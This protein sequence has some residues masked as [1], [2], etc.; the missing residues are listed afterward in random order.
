MSGSKPSGSGE[1]V[2][3]ASAAADSAA[4]DRG[5]EDSAAGDSAA[6]NSGAELGSVRNGSGSV[7][8]RKP[9]DRPPNPD[10]LATDNREADLGRRRTLWRS[11]AD[12]A[13]TPLPSD[14]I[15][16]GSPHLSFT[17]RHLRSPR[18][19]GFPRISARSPQ[20]TGTNTTNLPMLAKSIIAIA[21]ISR[22]AVNCGDFR[23][24]GRHSAEEK[25]TQPARRPL[26]VQCTAQRPPPEA[27]A[28]AAD[29][30]LRRDAHRW[31]AAPARAANTRANHG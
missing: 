14:T 24:S 11:A 20:K 21:S 10:A 19:D 5:T 13:V 15:L 12:I 9:S 30:R 4:E 6:G 25:T 18:L 27:R 28:S 1:D 29:E 2:S 3:A 31:P 8:K 22:T 26:A 17:C 23:F 16:R 7:R